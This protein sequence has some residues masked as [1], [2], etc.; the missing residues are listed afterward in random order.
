MRRIAK[1]ALTL[2]ICIALVCGFSA[3]EIVDSGE[4]EHIVRA[5]NALIEDFDSNLYKL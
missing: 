4:E 5:Y 2:F 1:A 3:C